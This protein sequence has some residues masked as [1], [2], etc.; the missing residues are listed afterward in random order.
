VE[1]PEGPHAPETECSAESLS[2]FPGGTS[3]PACGGRPPKKGAPALGRSRGGLRTTMHALCGAESDAV[4]LRITAGQAG[5][6]PVGEERLDA[7]ETREGSRPAAMDKAYDSTAIRA[8]LDAKGIDPV[9]PPKA[10]RLES[11]VSDQA[12]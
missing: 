6:A 7:L 1:G 11:M 10:N 12:Q 3:P 9:L 5:D 4:D 8:K 2:R